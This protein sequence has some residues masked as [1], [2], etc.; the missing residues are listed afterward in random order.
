MAIDPTTSANINPFA[1][2]GYISFIPIKPHSIGQG[3]W[4]I[5]A[6]TNQNL[7]HKLQNSSFTN[8][9]NCT[10]K[11][12]LAAGTYK[13]QILTA[14]H[15][16]YGILQLLLD[17]VGITSNDLYSAGLVNNV[18]CETASVS[19]A[20]SGLKDLKINVNGKNV[21]SGSYYVVVSTIIFQRTA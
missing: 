20:S 15:P 2:E 8:A 17:N 13:V 6:D 10:F 11:I 9:D 3:T 19:V 7:N 14:T 4:A 18:I 12:Y 16:N 21:S 5:Y 1:G